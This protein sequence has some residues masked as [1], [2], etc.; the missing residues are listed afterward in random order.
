VIG[1]IPREL[2]GRIGKIPELGGRL[3]LILPDTKYNIAAVGD[4]GCGTDTEATVNGIRSVNPE[5]VLALGDFSYQGAWYLPGYCYTS[6]MW[7]DTIKPIEKNMKLIMGNHDI[8]EPASAFS[9]RYDMLAI[10][11]EHFHMCKILPDKTRQCKL[12][13]SFDDHNIHFLVMNSEEN[14][15]NRSPQLSFVKKDL[16]SAASN[17]KIKWIIVSFHRSIYAAVKWQKPTTPPK[18][19]NGQYIDLKNHF[20]KIYHPLFDKYGVDLV[21]QGHVHNYQRTYPLKFDL[22]THGPVRTSTD[23][24]NY[25]NPDGEIYVSIGTAGIDLDPLPTDESSLHSI[26]P[27]LND[28]DYLAN[29]RDSYHGFLN[30]E[31]SKDQ[32][33]IVGTFYANNLAGTP[34]ALDH[35]SILKH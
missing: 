3:K 27:V 25:V 34:V 20:L 19:D 13:Y 15:G 5:V 6:N 22:E 21:L 28:Y 30:L 4:W 35:F 17:P 1:K 11:D 7:F 8:V 9:P 24:N 16:A 31:L 29:W 33:S 14:Y 18:L 12:Y 2:G 32:S 23:Q 26:D 10:Y